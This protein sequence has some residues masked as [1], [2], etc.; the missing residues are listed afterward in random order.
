[1]MCSNDVFTVYDRC[2]IRCL[3]YWHVGHVVL[4]L[5]DT[6]Y[7]YIRILKNCNKD[8]ALCHSTMSTEGCTEPHPRKIG[9]C[10]ITVSNLVEKNCFIM[11]WEIWNG[12][13]FAPFTSSQYHQ[14]WH[15]GANAW[16]IS[17]AIPRSFGDW[18]MQF[19][20]SLFCC[21]NRETAALVVAKHMLT[22][23]EYI[24]L[25]RRCVAQ[26]RSYHERSHRHEGLHPSLRAITQCPGCYTVA[27]GVQDSQDSLSVSMFPIFVTLTVSCTAQQNAVCMWK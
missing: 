16:L 8:S 4:N 24:F 13:V 10:C 9:F 23:W 27:A 14:Y 15:T 12:R 22:S 5:F 6:Q 21:Q 11:I 20:T 1:M 3:R 18:W 25:A 7:M 26:S 17:T 19:P 2:S